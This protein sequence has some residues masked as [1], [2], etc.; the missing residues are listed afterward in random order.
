M[1][2][3]MKLWIYLCANYPS[4]APPLFRERVGGFFHLVT[5]MCYFPLLVLKGIY[6]YWNY[7]YSFQGTYPQMEEFGALLSIPFEKVAQGVPCG[8]V[9]F[10]GPL[11]IPSESPLKLSIAE[12]VN[13]TSHCRHHRHVVF[14]TTTVLAS[15]SLLPTCCGFV[16]CQF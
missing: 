12:S 4:R 2:M 9:G 13:S 14:S 6:H 8:H 3:R 16:K 10:L 1:L 11:A 5:N 15:W 7:F